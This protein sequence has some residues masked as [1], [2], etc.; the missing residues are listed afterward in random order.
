[1]AEA[2]GTA[3]RLIGIGVSSLAEA[4]PEERDLIDNGSARIGAAE[5]A[6]DRVR[7]KFGKDALVRGLAF[8]EG[9]SGSM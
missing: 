2:D 7:A 6:V 9:G 3:F 4:A 8:G 5:Q 1:M